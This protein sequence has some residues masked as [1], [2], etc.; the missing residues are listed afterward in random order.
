MF[1]YS[2][3]YLQK[4]ES[5]FASNQKWRWHSMQSVGNRDLSTSAVKLYETVENDRQVFVHRL[6]TLIWITFDGFWPASKN[7]RKS[8]L[9]MDDASSFRQNIESRFSESGFFVI[10]KRFLVQFYWEPSIDI[11]HRF[12][13][14]FTFFDIINSF[15]AFNSISLQSAFHSFCCLLFSVRT[16]S[17]L[18][19][20]K[21]HSKW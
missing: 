19:R 3:P 8:L 4:S 11:I 20:L 14:I 12:A 9:K 5:L 17:A 21:S 16:Y 13:M 15:H 6:S 1:L 7:Q 10:P 18:F 2:G